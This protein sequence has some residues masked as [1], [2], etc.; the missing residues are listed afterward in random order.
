MHLFLLPTRYTSGVNR[1]GPLIARLRRGS[2]VTQAQLARRMGTTQPAVAKLERD[3]SNPTLATIV[4]ALDALGHE[5]SL[6][7]RPRPARVDE[8][9]IR[10]QLELSPQQRLKSLESMAREGDL[11]SEAGARS[12]AG[13]G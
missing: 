12:R 11:L 9:L 13:G 10:R 7:T 3:D 5:L 1:P 2:G 6:V 4:D 8:S